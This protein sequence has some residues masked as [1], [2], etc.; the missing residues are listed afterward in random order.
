MSDAA[1]DGGP[2]TE[3]N[4]EAIASGDRLVLLVS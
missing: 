1:D 2:I 4:N 3:T